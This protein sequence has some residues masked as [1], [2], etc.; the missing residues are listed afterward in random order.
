M[1]KHEKPTVW[2]T[3]VSQTARPLKDVHDVRPKY[4][5]HGKREKI[6]REIEAG[7]VKQ[8]EAR[9]CFQGTTFRGTRAVITSVQRFVSAIRT[10]AVI[11]IHIRLGDLTPPAAGKRR[12]RRWRWRWC[13]WCWCNTW[14]DLL[15]ATARGALAKS[16]RF[17][18]ANEALR[19]LVLT[20]RTV[21]RPIAH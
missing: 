10:I 3:Q 7:Q 8:Q 5:R 13:W 6:P 15:R 19:C 20:V 16:T 18:V 12:S 11:I 21:A 2:G 4:V 14:K 9:S 1:L 17:R